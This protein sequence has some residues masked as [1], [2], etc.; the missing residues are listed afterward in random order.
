MN[1]QKAIFCK[2]N[3][4]IGYKID[5]YHFKVI[6]LSQKYMYNIGKNIVKYTTR[7]I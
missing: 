7:I 6:N 1:L 2:K 3:I 4:K 5:S